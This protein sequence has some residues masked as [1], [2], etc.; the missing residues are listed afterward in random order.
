MYAASHRGA[1]AARL[2]P[3][4]QLVE[5]L[6]RYATAY[7]TMLGAGAG[8]SAP[9]AIERNIVEPRVRM[10]EN[11]SNPTRSAARRTAPQNSHRVKS[12]S[13]MVAAITG[14]GVHRRPA[15]IRATCAIRPLAR[16]DLDQIDLVVRHA[17]VTGDGA[18]GERGRFYLRLCVART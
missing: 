16:Y 11:F 9:T 2:G 3:R 8:T 15:T 4:H 13:A 10:Y 18:Y 12:G 14:R 1:A 7:D 17:L 5:E 6:L